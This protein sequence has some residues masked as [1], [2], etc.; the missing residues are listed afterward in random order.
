AMTVT[1]A[2]GNTRIQYFLT[3]C[4]TMPKLDHPVRIAIIWKHK[5]D[6]EAVKFL[7]TNRIHWNNEKSVEIYRYRWTGT[8]T[9]HRDAKQE[10]GL[11]DCP[12]RNGVGQTR[13]TYLVMLAY[14][15]LVRTLGNGSLNEW[16]REK[17]ATIGEACRMLLSESTRNM[18]TW[19][20]EELN[21]TLNGQTGKSL[22]RLLGRL[23]LAS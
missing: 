13:P 17:L 19:I 9:F 7:V 5:K 21:V 3:D 11:G 15:L 22:N 6:T 12:L 16:C 8:E 14:R 2:E 4:V 20:L 18:V 1:D 10:L 23:G